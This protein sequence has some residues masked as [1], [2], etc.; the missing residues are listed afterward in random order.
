[1]GDDKRGAALAETFDGLHGG[2]FSFVVQYAGGFI[3]DGDI[4]LFVA[5]AGMPMRWR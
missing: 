4:G 2:L 1:V 3:K 5:C